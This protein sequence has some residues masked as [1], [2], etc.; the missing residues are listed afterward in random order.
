MHVI[1]NLIKYNPE[2]CVAVYSCM[3]IISSQA[4][5]MGVRL[6]EPTIIGGCDLVTRLVQGYSLVTKITPL[7]LATCYMVTRLVQASNAPATW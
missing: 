7:N 3:C 5:L 1:Q 2:F 4:P 6:Q